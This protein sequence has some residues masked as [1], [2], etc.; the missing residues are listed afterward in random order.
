[1]LAQT[2]FAALVWATGRR[3]ASQLGAGDPGPQPAEGIAREDDEPRSF[4]LRRGLESRFVALILAYQVLSALGSQLSDFLVYDR[5]SAQYPDPTDLAGFLAV[6]TAV[7]NIAAIAFLVVLA[8]PLLR[9]F[10]LQLGITA[11]PIVLT[12]FALFMV[13]VNAVSGGTSMALL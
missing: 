12:V 2:A 11:N 13:A 5:A 7:M 8:G 4:S 10:G 1:A 3:Y 9:R 6:Y